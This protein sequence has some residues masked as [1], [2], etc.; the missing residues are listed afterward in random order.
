M[1]TKIYLEASEPEYNQELKLSDAEFL[2][3]VGIKK[4]E[5]IPPYNFKLTS[6]Q[7]VKIA[8]Y[9]SNA[10]LAGMYLTI[11]WDLVPENT[12]EKKEISIKNLKNVRNQ[13]E[14]DDASINKLLKKYEGCPYNFNQYE[15]YIKEEKFLSALEFLHLIAQCLNLN[16]GYFQ[17]YSVQARKIISEEI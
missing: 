16:T 9:L 2:D 6:N 14:L 17:Q 15:K 4:S 5:I 13:I 1:R 3:I 7:R 10:K 8:S 12:Q 11:S